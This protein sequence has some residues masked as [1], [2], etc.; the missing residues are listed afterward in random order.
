ME[1]YS[2][3]SGLNSEFLDNIV[4]DVEHT[5]PRKLTLGSTTIDISNVNM[6]EKDE[7][8]NLRVTRNNDGGSDYEDYDDSSADECDD[9]DDTKT[10]NEYIL[11]L[12]INRGWGNCK[13]SFVNVKTRL[14]QNQL[15]LRIFYQFKY[16]LPSGERID[17]HNKMEY[18]F[19]DYEKTGIVLSEEHAYI[20]VA[21][22]RSPDEHYNNSFQ[23]FI[24]Y[25]YRYK[26]EKA[27]SCSIM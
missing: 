6:G 19:S 4:G 10:I 17:R 11:A 25:L 12:Y 14:T 8:G 22:R 18:L 27:P 2:S 15:L 5:N 24:S 20:H 3:R 13:V 1:I 26:P 23:D 21:K 9:D 16:N 7:H